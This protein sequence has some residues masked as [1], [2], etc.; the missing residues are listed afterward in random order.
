M[1]AFRP[2]DSVEALQERMTLMRK[3]QREFAKFTQEID[4][5]RNLSEGKTVSI[6]F[7]RRKI[8]EKQHK[9]R[10]AFSHA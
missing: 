4:E 10:R 8:C 7:F 2:I 3:A 5:L 6:C 1:Q 9:T